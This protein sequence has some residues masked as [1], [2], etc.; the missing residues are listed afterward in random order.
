[1]ASSRLTCVPPRQ[2]S[3]HVEMR[4]AEPCPL[5][6]PFSSSLCLFRSPRLSACSIGVRHG[7]GAELH[8]RPPPSTLLPNR[9]PGI[10]PHLALPR[11]ASLPG[12]T[13]AC[14]APPLE[15]LSRLSPERVAALPQAIAEQAVATSR[16]ARAHWHCTATSPPLE[17]RHRRATVSSTP[18][19]PAA[20][21]KPPRAA[22]RPSETTSGCGRTPWCS[23]STSSPPL[24]L[25]RPSVANSHASPAV[26]CDQGPRAQIR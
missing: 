21:A 1:M 17:G 20:V 5:A 22:S 15:R 4:K 14:N 3:C 16:C 8:V 7:Q 10:P 25:L 24:S 12:G 26:F 9:S 2:R 11:R 18:V 13:A 23:S 6:S 19:P